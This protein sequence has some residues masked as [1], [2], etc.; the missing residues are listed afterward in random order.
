MTTPTITSYPGTIPAKGQSNTDFDTN[1]DA[2]LVWL[3]TLNIPELQILTPWISGIRDE[4]A[5]T[6]LS[7]TLPSIA[8]KAG[9]WVRVNA[10]ETAMEFRT[11]AEVLGDIGAATAAQ[12]VKADNAAPLNSPALT[13]NPTAPTQTAGNDSTL[14]ATTAFVSESS[15]SVVASDLVGTDGHI[16]YASGLIMQWGYKADTGTAMRVPYNTTFSTRVFS[17]QMSMVRDLSNNQNM[18]V[19][20]DYATDLTGFDMLWDSFADGIM[21]FAIGI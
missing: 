15:G 16:E 10:G 17:I 7:G 21:W 4:V 20:T 2:Y 3:S 5:A 9:N 14:V 19:A 13:G 6:A 1:V 18:T 8:G 11:D 12:G